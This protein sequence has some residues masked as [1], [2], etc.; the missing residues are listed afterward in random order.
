MKIINCI[1]GSEE[2]HE[3]KLGVVSTSKFGLILSKGSPRGLYM[4][5][6]AAERLSGVKQV[7]YSDKNTKNGIELEPFAR[8]YY[9]AIND[10][11]VQQVGF[12]KKDE[13][14]GTSPDGLV[15]SNG[16]AEIKSPIPS[17]QIETILKGVMPTE[18]KPQVQG[19]LWI[20]EREW[21][22]FISYCPALA[23]RPYF[24]VRVFRD[25]EYIHTIAVETEIFVSDLREMIEK[26]TVSEF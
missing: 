6:L 15:Y 24:C 14:V 12:I 26:L 10:C 13:W 1:Q 20:I 5:K 7:S 16:L 2:W 11:S 23:I 4:R 21:C 9:E 22:D 19:Q 3:A 8:R 25:E 18:H 17:T